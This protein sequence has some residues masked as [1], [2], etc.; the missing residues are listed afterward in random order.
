MSSSYKTIHPVKYYRDFLSHDV[1][2]DGRGLQKFR[3]VSVNVGSIQ[4]ADGSAIVKIG[5]TTVV[6]GIKAELAT[7]K[8]E[9]PNLGF[10]VPN[11]ELGPLC[12][13]R[14][15][16]GPPSDQA[17]VATNFIAETLVNSECLDLKE[18]CIQTEHLVWVLRCDLI[19]LDHDG[20]IFDACML[21][22]VAAL[23]TVRLPKVSY[24]SDTGA[25]SVSKKKK[26]LKIKHCPIATTFSIF[27]DKLLIDPTTEEESLSS[28][29]VTVVI[30][31]EKLSSV[32]KPGGS[33]LNN[34]QLQD[35]ISSAIKRGDHIYKLIDTALE[36]FNK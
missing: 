35:C 21:A 7:P 20:A 30:Q 15:R 3:P 31:G 16:P 28:G 4:T 8:T 5:N 17:Q 22:L 27:D 19:C 9:E 1:R 34:T 29:I 32:H 24:D 6:C 23:H 2:P 10:V 25:V 12:S 13:Y 14:F 11:V 36:S 26:K 33:P 18:L